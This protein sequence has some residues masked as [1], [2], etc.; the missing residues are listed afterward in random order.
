MRRA[1]CSGPR[2]RPSR[3]RAATDCF[4]LRRRAGA[5]SASRRCLASTRRTLTAARFAAGRDRG[6]DRGRVGDPPAE[7]RRMGG[8]R[9]AEPAS[10]SVGCGARPRSPI[11]LPRGADR[12]PS[13]T[14][15]PEATAYHVAEPPALDGSLAGF[16]DGD[17]AAARSRRPV[18]PQPRS[19]IPGRR[20][21]AR[22]GL[23]RLG[24]D[25]TLRRRRGHQAGSDLPAGRTRRRS[26]WT[27]SPI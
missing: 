2:A 10:R 20:R 23:A 3:A 14:A 4:L 6:R 21:F 22:S 19:P 5:T 13:S 27:T 17:L 1:S 15:P 11:D 12:E 16:A 25:G 26:G 9:T 24:R 18:P 8:A 7:Q